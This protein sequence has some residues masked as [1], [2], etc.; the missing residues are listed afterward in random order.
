MVGAGL[1][2]CGFFAGHPRSAHGW[3]VGA[4]WVGMGVSSIGSW[5]G[6]WYGTRKPFDDAEMF[7]LF[8][9]TTAIYGLLTA[10]W[11][12]ARSIAGHD[13]YRLT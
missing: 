4:V 2:V 9:W 3:G 12:I 10:I 13:T 8:T 1:T 7:V 6:L 5:A 11:V